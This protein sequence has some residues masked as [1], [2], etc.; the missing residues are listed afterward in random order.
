M[1]TSH[2]GWLTC[3]PGYLKRNHQ[4]LDQPSFSFA[5][6]LAALPSDGGPFTLDYPTCFD[7]YHIVLDCGRIDHGNPQNVVKLTGKDCQISL[8]V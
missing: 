3:L 8:T 4:A 5:F 6:F 2:L 1:L 7:R